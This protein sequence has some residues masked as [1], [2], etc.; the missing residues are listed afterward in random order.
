MRK[1]LYMKRASRYDVKALSNTGRTIKKMGNF[2]FHS[3]RFQFTAFQFEQH[4]PFNFLQ[5]LLT[6]NC[7]PAA[8]LEA[9]PNLD[10][11][12][13]S[14]QNQNE[15]VKHGLGQSMSPSESSICQN[16]DLGCQFNALDTPFQIYLERWQFVSSG[17]VF[18]GDPD[19][20]LRD[21]V[22]YRVLGCAGFD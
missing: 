10:S 22:F 13:H 7:Y 15:I 21:F 18:C 5:Q 2:Y 11:H 16:E 12:Y 14:L 17:F 8:V 19:C 20:V 1:V 9:Q 4:L 3:K 6:Q